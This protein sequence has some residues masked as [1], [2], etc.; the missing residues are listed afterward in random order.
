M[1]RQISRSTEIVGRM[2]DGI[3]HDHAVARRPSRFL[4]GIGR[5][6]WSIAEMATRNSLAG[7]AAR[8]WLS[9]LLFAEALLVIGSYIFGRVEVRPLAW[10]LLA[11][12]FGFGVLIELAGIW[13]AKPTFFKNLLGITSVS[14]A[15]GT[16]ALAVFGWPVAMHE[17]SRVGPQVAAAVRLVR[18]G[19]LFQVGA[20]ILVAGLA[21]LAGR[22]RLRHPPGR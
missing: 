15:L 10:E 7:V 16:V 8:Y 6:I 9:L 13:I 2:L 14:I 20:L 22:Y 5:L 17:F 12:T 3:A 21:F 1:L 18:T 11:I 4:V 19:T